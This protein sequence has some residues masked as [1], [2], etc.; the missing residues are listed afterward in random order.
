MPLLAGQELT[1]SALRYQGFYGEVRVRG[2]ASIKVKNLNR[3]RYQ[4]KIHR[5]VTAIEAPN[6]LKPLSSLLIKLA[7]GKSD[8]QIT[9][10]TTPVPDVLKLQPFTPDVLA[11]ETSQIVYLKNNPTISI[12]I[13]DAVRQ[14]DNAQRATA[15][16]VRK[17]RTFIAL[18]SGEFSK[19]QRVHCKK[20]LQEIKTTKKKRRW[21]QTE[22]LRRKRVFSRVD[23]NIKEA[24][25]RTMTRIEVAKWKWKRAEQQ[26][27]NIAEHLHA[28]INTGSEISASIAC[29]SRPRKEKLSLLVFDLFPPETETGKAPVTEMPLITF[30]CEHPLSFSIGGFYSNLIDKEY[31]FR[32]KM[33]ADSTITQVIGFNNQSKFRVMPGVMV[34]TRLFQFLNGF[35]IHLSFGGALTNFR[36]EQGTDIEFIIG[37][38]FRINK[39]VFLTLGAHFDHVLD[40]QDYEGDENNFELGT[41]KIEGLKSVPTQKFYK[42]KSGFGISYRFIPK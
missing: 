33:G 25:D 4:Y 13:L 3:V 31:V 15:E 29:G 6:V 7:N 9:T 21:P 27:A 30:V 8:P 38:S 11:Q 35:E 18:S 36:G 24:L 41:P 37:G 12:R 2:K 42:F 34:N 32:P 16:L 1:F 5:Q 20:L 39:S 19:K 22:G 26:I 23:S 28:A 14:A 17:L 10:I 40:L